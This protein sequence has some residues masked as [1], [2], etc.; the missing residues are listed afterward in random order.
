MLSAGGDFP[1]R[2]F[3]GY[4]FFPKARLLYGSITNGAGDGINVIGAEFTA[5]VRWAF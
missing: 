1:V 4:D 5:T 3:G 2:V